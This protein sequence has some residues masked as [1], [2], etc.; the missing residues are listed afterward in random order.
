MNR[1]NPREVYGDII[2][3][4]HH[5]SKK[6]PHMSLY[7]RAAQFSPFAAL[8]GYDD[9]VREEARLTETQRELSETDWD[10]LDRKLALIAGRI[11]ENDHPEITVTYFVPDAR[12]TGGRYEEMTGIVK[13]IDAVEQAIIFYGPNMV[14]GG[15]IIAIPMISEIQS[16]LL[17]GI[18][19]EA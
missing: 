13:R 7:D 11:A 17:D 8:T 6:H 1:E 19:D 5:Q 12:K 14:S 9:M 18:D 15:Q 10:V 16:K 3:L 4:P 2:D